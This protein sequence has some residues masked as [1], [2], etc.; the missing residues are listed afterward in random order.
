[1]S[2]VKPDLFD[3]DV[4][5]A[6]AGGEPFRFRLNGKEWELPHFSSLDRHIMDAADDPAGLAALALQLALGE[7]WAEFDAAPVSLRQLNALF[8]RWAAHAGITLGESSASTD[9]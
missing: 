9:S 7:R 2:V 3:L 8:E 6:E 1:M 4:L 5:E